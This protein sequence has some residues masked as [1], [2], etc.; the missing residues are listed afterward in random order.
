VHPETVIKGMVGGQ[1]TM[2]GAME[3]VFFNDGFGR[4]VLYKVEYKKSG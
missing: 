3:V 4:V 1:L 2:E